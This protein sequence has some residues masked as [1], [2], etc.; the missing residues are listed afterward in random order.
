MFLTIF[1]KIK[2]LKDNSLKFYK[3]NLFNFLSA[4]WLENFVKNQLYVFK[5]V[6]KNMQLYIYKLNISWFNFDF[7]LRLFVG[8][9]KTVFGIS[10]L[11][12]LFL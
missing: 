3:I 5:E 6:L 8:L 10:I 9:A 7:V 11:I 4:T 2:K 1:S 12:L